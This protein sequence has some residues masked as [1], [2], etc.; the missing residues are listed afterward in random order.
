M[1]Q[2]SSEVSVNNNGTEKEFEVCMGVIY[3]SLLLL[4]SYYSQFRQKWMCPAVRF[5]RYCKDLSPPA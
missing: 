5:V 3:V 4:D 2:C 1:F